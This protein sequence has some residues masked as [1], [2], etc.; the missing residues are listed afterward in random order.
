MNHKAVDNL[1]AFMFLALE[2]KRITI[3]QDVA[4]IVL[5]KMNQYT[6]I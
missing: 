3:S 1:E 5:A 4:L 6:T 2:S